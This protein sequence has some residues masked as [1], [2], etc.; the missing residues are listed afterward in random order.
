MINF[1][2]YIEKCPWLRVDGRCEG[3]RES[4]LKCNYAHCPILYWI[5]RLGGKEK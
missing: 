2:E 4:G 1:L 3:S 5:E